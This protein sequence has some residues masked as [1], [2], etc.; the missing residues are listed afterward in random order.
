MSAALFSQAPP[1]AILEEWL[2]LINVQTLILRSVAAQQFD[3]PEWAE[4]IFTNACGLARTMRLHQTQIFPGETNTYNTLERAKVAHGSGQKHAVQFRSD[5]RTSCLLLLVANG[6]QD[7][8]IIDT[9]NA[10]ACQK[11]A[12]AN[13]DEKPCTIEANTVSFTSML[14]A[15]SLPAFFTLL[16]DLLQLS[17]NDQV[18]NSDFG[19]LRRV[20]A[21]YINSAERMQFRSYH[22]K[23]AWTFKQL[24][25]IISLIRHPEQDQSIFMASTASTF[26]MII[27]LNAQSRDF[28][29]ISSPGSIGDGS[30]FSYSPQPAGSTFFS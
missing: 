13:R 10:L 5:A 15:F 29:K 14:D 1:L 28:F 24:L 8:Q 12:T 6:V 4:L 17:D 22:R 21:C 16:K 7:P 3:L 27:S 30:T 11:I 9:F 20:S 23:V 18:S 19:S 2:L 25:M 26:G